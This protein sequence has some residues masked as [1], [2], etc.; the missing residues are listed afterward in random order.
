MKT[1]IFTVAFSFLF[2]SQSGAQEFQPEDIDRGLVAISIEESGVYLSWRWLGSDP[3]NLGFNVYRGEIQINGELITGSTNFIDS[4]GTGGDTYTVVPVIGE[5]EQDPSNTVSPWSQNYLNIPIQSPEDGITPGFSCEDGSAIRNFPGGQEYSYT[6]NDASTADLDGDGQYEIILKWDP[7]N[8]HDNAHCGYTGN[9]ILDAYKMDGTLLWRIDLGVNVRSG[10]HYSPFMAYDLNGDGMAEVVCRTTSGTRD[11][12]GEFISDGPA[13]SANHEADFRNSAGYILS[14]PEFLTVFNGND[15]TELTTTRLQPARGSAGD[16]G[17]TYGNRVDRF[18]GAVAYLGGENPS[19]VWARGIYE[20][21]ELTAFDLIEGDLVLRWHFKSTEGYSNWEGMGSH[22]LSVADVDGDNRDEIIYGNCAIDD[23]G[24]GL[25]HL[26]GSIGRATGDAMHLA[27]IIPDRPGLEKWGCA[28]GSGPGAHLVDAATGQE[29]WVTDPAD[30]GRVTAGD[31][32]PG[33]IGMEVW[34][35]TDGLRSAGNVRVGDTPSSTNHVVWWDGDLGRE[36][37]DATNIRKY[38]GGILLLADGCSSNNGSKSN[39]SLQADIFGD[40]REEVIWRTSDNNNLRIYTTTDI[41]EYRIKTLM[42]DPVYRLGVAWQNNSYNQPPHTSFFLGYEMFTPDSLWPPSKPLNIRGIALDD[43]VQI[44]WDENSDLDLA[45]Y[46]LFRGIHHD[47]LTLFSDVGNVTS[48]M[49]TNVTNDSSYYYAVVAYDLDNNESIFSDI[50]QVTPTIRPDAPTDISSRHDSNSIL[51]T[52]SSQNFDYVSTI[53]IHR[54]L[55]G[56]DFTLYETLDK[57]VI[58]F[59]DSNL[60]FTTTYYYRISITDSNGIE[61]FPSAIQSVRP[62]LFFTFQSEDADFSGEIFVENNHIGFNGT[63][64]TNFGGNNSAVEF[65][66]IP[67]FGGGERMLVFRYALGNTDRS[68]YLIVNGSTRNITMSG[69]GEWTNY[70]FDTVAVNLNAGYDNTIRFETTGN[71]FGNLDE[72]RIIPQAVTSVS[73]DDKENKL[74]SVFKLYQNYPNP[75]NPH[76][77][78]AF[79][80]PN[81]VNV[82]ISIYDVSGRLVSNLVNENYQAGSYKI[83]FDGSN[84]ASGLYFVRSGMH[85]AERGID[86]VFTKKIILLK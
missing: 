55:T 12:S 49:D 62:G 70:E 67:G 77:T 50:I 34:G 52:W 3:D 36:L 26:R 63:A 33:F 83:T 72:I 14:G 61:S 82:T 76:T 80:L 60:S 22:N 54:S 17:D 59:V 21:V 74:P 29:L 75:F 64:F 25:W 58:T 7:T 79:D 45:G 39:P 16:W 28:E 30:V 37:L 40:W 32:V 41:T 9:T 38:G 44:E 81:A 10:A 53:N 18:L 66:Y 27:D 84:L 6:A 48:Y 23:D 42:H 65:T 20:K 15:G 46:R 43:T 68:G 11:A 86:H 35:G 57:S 56:S 85:S 71:D 78:I 19:V 13:D 51:L 31:L 5:V 24:T 2:I 73:G 1:L 4:A 69:T 8:S 47:S